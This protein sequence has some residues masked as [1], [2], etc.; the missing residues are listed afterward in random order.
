MSEHLTRY[1][2]VTTILILAVFFLLLGYR[3]PWWRTRKPASN[4]PNC[5]PGPLSLPIIGTRWVFTSFGGYN[6]EKIHEFY[7]DMY[8]KFGPIVKEEALWNVP[9]VSVFERADIEIVLRSS[10]R[11]PV[12]PPTEAIAAYRRSRP[13]RYVSAGIVNEQ[14]ATWQHL[15]SAL[16][17]DLTSPRTISNYLPV[18]FEIADDFC[19]LIKTHRSTDNTIANL[20]HLASRL[21]LEATCALVLGRRMGFLLPDGES[22]TSRRLAKAVHEHF[23]SSRDTYYGLP[24][25]KLWNTEAYKRLV[26]SEEEIY[27]LALELVESADDAVRESPVFQ[28]VL[29]ADV[30][31]REKTAAIVDFIAAGIHTLSNSLLFLLYLIGAN[32]CVQEKLHEEL[33][34]TSD[35]SY[36]KACVTESFRLL[37]TANCIARI[38]E[39][40]LQLSTHKINPG[41]VILCHTGIA[42]RNPSNFMNPSQ[43]KPERWLN[44]EKSKT[45]STATYIVAPFGVGRR[46]CPGKRFIEQSLPVILE[47]VARRFVLENVQPLELR[48]EFLLVPKVPLVM[49][50]VDR[51]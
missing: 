4:D 42:C 3:P 31:D 19:N 6:M 36:L 17:S 47:R 1:L 16:T 48:F 14:G 21:G 5:L 29:R 35:Y 24:L 2:D 32:G 39:Q 20:E 46:S 23:I 51:V 37:P 7:A 9:V 45:A 27:E 43:Y 15:R 11:Y 34:T 40:T 28:S 22:Q 41:T 44:G 8:E 33:D 12:R 50:F 49:K 30:D 13:D 38:T 26:K 18:I 25:W 10:G